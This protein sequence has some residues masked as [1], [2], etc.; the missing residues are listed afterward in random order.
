MRDKLF[1]LLAVMLLLCLASVPVFSGTDSSAASLNADSL[2]KAALDN[3][4]DLQKLNIENR[5]ASI[6]LKNAEAARLPKVDFQTALTWM[7]KPMI[8]PITLTAGELG[9]YDI[10]GTSILLPSEDMTIYKGMEDTN[11]DFKFIFDQPVYTWGKITNAINLYTRASETSELNIESK[12]KEIRTTISI[13]FYSLYYISRIESSLQQQSSDAERLIHIADESYKSGFI[14]YTELLAARINAKQL[15][16]AG[17]ELNEQKEQALLA[18]SKLT[19]IKELTWQML[20]FSV[21]KDVNDIELLSK[22][23]YYESALKNSPEIRMLEKLKDINELRVEISKGTAPYKPDIGLHI[24]LG[25]SGPRFPFIETDWFGQDSLSLTTTLAL[26]TTVYEGG[27][28][29]L[30]VK[31]DL[32][33]LEKTFYEYELGT[34]SL[35]NVISES[36]LKLELN[37]QNIDYYRLLQEN[38]EQQIQLK[39]TQLE[40]GSGNETDLLTEKMNL[41]THMIN[42]YRES[43]DFYK[44]YF[45]LLGAASA[46]N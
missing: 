3:N 20:D 40:A 12:R 21:M 39:Q 25:Y 5:K 37:R 14:L 33:E 17:A 24:E 34:D 4:Y 15:A 19:G 18:L 22:D 6:D 1:L 13:Y 35:R 43:I 10:G 16:I 44:N 7:S 27:K 29:Q 31:K 11:Y 32:E 9:S 30:Q 26:Q 2:Y 41:S 42:E 23:A 36:L 8:E 28:Q 45:T 46:D 38:D